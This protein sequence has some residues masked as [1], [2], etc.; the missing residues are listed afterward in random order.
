MTAK[1]GTWTYDEIF[2]FLRSPGRYIPGTKMTFVGLPRA[3]DRLNLIAFM[4][5]WSDTPP[6]LP[7]HKAQQA[8]VDTGAKATKPA[9]AKAKP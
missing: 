2:R 5:S 8:T 3:Q 9:P 1:G 6:P 7:P 4:R